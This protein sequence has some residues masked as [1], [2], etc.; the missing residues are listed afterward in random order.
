MDRRTFL[1][2]AAGA[3]GGA[4]CLRNRGDATYDVGMSAD[5]FLPEAVEASVGEPVVWRNTSSRAHSVTAY[6]DQIPPDASFFASGGFESEQAARD[7]WLEQGGG[8]IYGG[9]TY[10]QTFRVPGTYHYFC[11]PHEPQ[12][13]VGQVVVS[14]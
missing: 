6:E 7:A 11:I 14:E 12:G 5:R 10:R 2:A 4:G 9:E 8:T 3:V 13:M 1:A